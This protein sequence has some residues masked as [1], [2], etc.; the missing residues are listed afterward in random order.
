MGK[1][2]LFLILLIITTCLFLIGWFR[3]SPQY[4]E[5]KQYRGIK[6]RYSTFYD[7]VK[8]YGKPDVS[9]AS[10]GSEIVKFEYDLFFFYKKEGLKFYGKSGTG[11][12]M[13]SIKKSPIFK[14]MV[15]K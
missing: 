11:Y 5:V 1:K 4:I 15:K 12:G 10:D 7:V 2:A 13:R 8:M 9:T 14:I 3:K 6:V